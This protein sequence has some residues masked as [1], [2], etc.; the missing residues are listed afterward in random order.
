MHIVLLALLATMAIPTAPSA[1][2]LLVS[3]REAAELLGIS[4]RM[5]IKLVDAGELRSLKIG[6]RRLVPMAA[7]RDYI[8][9]R[10]A[11]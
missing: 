1:E 11:S 5:T 2:P 10:L 6:R 9:E 3:I 4:Q 7:V 8:A